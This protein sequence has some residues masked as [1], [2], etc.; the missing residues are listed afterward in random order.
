MLCKSSET[1]TEIMRQQ[2]DSF[3]TLLATQASVPRTEAA[4]EV[5]IR[6]HTADRVWDVEVVGDEIV[7]SWCCAVKLA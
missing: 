3:E 4:V 2:L 7:N 1:M 6:Q 5:Q